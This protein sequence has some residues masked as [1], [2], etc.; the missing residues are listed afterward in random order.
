MIMMIIMIMMMI[1][2]MIIIIMI[3]II[4]IMIM[5]VIHNTSYVI[6]I[7]AC[8]AGPRGVPRRVWPRARR[9]RG[10]ASDVTSPNLCLRHCTI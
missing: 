2:I 5:I 8:L 10:R 3:I 1:M 9:T 4:M 6:M 7:S